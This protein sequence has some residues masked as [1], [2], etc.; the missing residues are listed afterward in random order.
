MKRCSIVLLLLGMTFLTACGWLSNEEAGGDNEPIARVFNK[1]LYKSELE[2]MISEEYSSEDSSNLSNYYVYEWV[3]R[4]LLLKKAELELPNSKEDIDQK[5]EDYR[6]SLLLFLYEQKLL[7][8]NQDTLVTDQ[9]ILT[10]YNEHQDNFVLRENILKAQ[11]VILQKES[12]QLEDVR[13]WLKDGSESSI[14][15]LQAYCFQYAINFSLAPTWNTMEIFSQEIPI[16]EEEVEEFLTN[17][18]LYETKDAVNI[19]LVKI[20]DYGLQGKIA[21]L[22][23]K[24]EEIRKIQLNKKRLNHIKQMKQKIYEEALDKNQYEVFN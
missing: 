17:S 3:H 16:P 12:P 19:Y 24:K 15:E 1:F 4:N 2:K 11:F 22:D 5:I 14:K 20:A 9:D 10:Y 6:A 21:P 8:Q 23:Y 13:A 18:S 7:E